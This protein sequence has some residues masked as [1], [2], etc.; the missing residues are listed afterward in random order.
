MR[1]FLCLVDDLVDFWELSMFINASVPETYY[2][3][4]WQGDSDMQKE[5]L[6]D[7]TDIVL[8]TLTD[9]LN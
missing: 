5:V 8:T 9:D 4:K 6:L 2:L 7:T 3:M 1:I